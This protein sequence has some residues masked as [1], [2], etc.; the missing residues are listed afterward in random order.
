[1][2]DEQGHVQSPV[3][4]L[5]DVTEQ[6]KAFRELEHRARQFQT[7][8]LDISEAESR[9]RKRLAEILHDDLQQVLAGAKFHLSLLR[10]RAKY[11]PS[12][13]A[14]AAQIDHMIKD[15]IDK[16]RSLSH[17]LCPAVLHHSG[18][19]ARGGGS[20]RPAPSRT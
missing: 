10:N 5:E 6:Q 15:A 19:W 20:G 9:E 12:L 4:N 2:L 3:L 8:T 18:Q 11:D 16:S 13:Q 1:L 7:L 14:T 17:E